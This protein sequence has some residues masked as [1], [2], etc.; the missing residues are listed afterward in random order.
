[1]EQRAVSLRRSGS[2]SQQHATPEVLAR[3]VL[4]GATK[5][6]LRCPSL[7]GRRIGVRAEG[8][9]SDT[10]PAQGDVHLSSTLHSQC[11]SSL[12]C[13]A[14]SGGIGACA[15]YQGR[16]D[17]DRPYVNAR[18]FSD[19]DATLTGARHQ[20]WRALA[21]TR[22]PLG[23]HPTRLS[24]HA[25]TARRFL[26]RLKRREEWEVIGGTSSQLVRARPSAWLRSATR[27]RVKRPDRT[28]APTAAPGPVNCRQRMP[29][30]R[31]LRTQGGPGVLFRRTSPCQA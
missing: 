4:R 5:G 18:A 28:F 30:T 23:R 16:D 29:R 19:G 7:V 22:G 27:F 1:M 24:G 3:R 2:E 15:A 13:R 8:A 9:R 26:P 6:R 31:S 12:R 20:C 14:T 17:R 21:A 10:R 11:G 25:P